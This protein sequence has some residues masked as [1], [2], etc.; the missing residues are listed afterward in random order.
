[1]PDA[2]P[3]PRLLRRRD[4][5]VALGFGL[6]HRLLDQDVRATLDALQGDRG[7]GLGRSADVHHIGLLSTIAIV[8]VFAK[9]G[10]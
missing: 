1:M 2:D 4:H 3:A 7:V 10:R 6:A 5:R 9:G 8:P